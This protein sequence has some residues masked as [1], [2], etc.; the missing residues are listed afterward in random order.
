[1]LGIEDYGSDNESDNEVALELG[2]KSTSS[3]AAELPPPPK[4]SFSLPAP[5]RSIITQATNGSSAPSKTKRAPKKI[6]IGLP[7]LLP[8]DEESKSRDEPPPAKKPRLTTGAGASSLVSMLPAPKQKTSLKPAPQRVLGAGQGPGLVFRTSHTKD[9]APSAPSP[10]GDDEDCMHHTG[11]TSTDN[12][13]TAQSVQSTFMIPPSLAKGKANVSLDDIN[14]KQN[15]RKVSS[16][17]PVD[18]FSSDGLASSSKPPISS[19]P[20]ATPSFSISSAPRVDMFTPPEPSPD[21]PYP[22]YY[23]TPT[24]A[25]EAYDSEYYKK[26]YQKWK[27]DYDSHV[28]ALEKGSARGFEAAATADAQEVDM[29]S[30]MEKARKE[31]QE[32]EAKKA[33]TKAGDAEPAQPRMNVQGAK[34]GGRARSRHQLTTLLTEAYTNREALEERIAQGRRNRKEAGNKY[35]F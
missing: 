34:L 27:K 11:S 7:A 26:F 9:S 10:E 21:D 28:R 16:A 2:T 22:G 15:P 4:S 5:K 18:L 24:G 35:G 13:E 31:I 19:T 32:R 29:A 6:A 17:P 25:W 33:V 3:L 1:M 14:P 8:E 30:E 20:L 23:L 12:P